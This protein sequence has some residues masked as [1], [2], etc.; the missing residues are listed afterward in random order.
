[1]FNWKR[2]MGSQSTFI[3]YFRRFTLEKTD[4]GH[5]RVMRHWWDRQHIKKITVDVDSTVLERYGT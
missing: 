5:I 4:R 1:M 2:D 3:R